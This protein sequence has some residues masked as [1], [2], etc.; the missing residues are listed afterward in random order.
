MTT[1]STAS[2]QHAQDMREALAKD[3]LA[4]EIFKA[5]QAGDK[6]HKT[7]PLGECKIESD[8]LLVNNLICV[9]DSPELYL[10]ILKICYNYPAI[11][12]PSRAATYE[13]V[14]RDYWW[15]KMRQTIAQYVRNCDT[16]TRIKS[17]HHAPYV[18]LKPL[19]VPFRKW[20]SISLELITG[21]LVSQDLN[22]LLVVVDRLSKMA[23]Y[24]PITNDVNS[25][26]IARLFLHN[27]FHLHGLPDSIVS[28]R[29]TQFVSQFTRSLT[30]LLGIQQKVS[31]TFHPQ[32][33]SQTECINAVVEQYLRGYCSYQQHNWFELISMTEFSY[34]NTLSA[35]LGITPFYA[36]YGSSPHYQ[37][38]PNNT[39]KLPAPSVVREY[40]DRLS[41]LDFYLYSGMTWS[42]AAYSEQAN[43]ARIRVPKLEAGDKVWLLRRHVKTSRP[44]TKLDFKRLDK[45]SI[46]PKVSSHAYNLDLPPSMKIQPVLHVSLLEPATTD[47]LP[48]QIQ[49]PPPPVIVDDVLEWEVDEIVDA[50]LRGRTLEYLPCW[51]GFDELIWEPANMFANGSS[52][53]K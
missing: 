23:H 4:Q 46:L 52:I 10:R 6:H 2:T 21:L 13:L 35:T 33:D 32:T 30:D 28:D 50:C 14:S 43:K 5:L 44:S 31:T 3:P 37:I 18:L 34:N 51:T 12:H 27:I 26:G 41:E 19:Q 15:P 17:T 24:I 53:V 20:S 45:F 47:P 1:L 22:A 25:K 38:H 49:P 11:G 42:Q 40:A 16:C 9:P 48:G 36:I 7:M 8:L 39:A 29:G